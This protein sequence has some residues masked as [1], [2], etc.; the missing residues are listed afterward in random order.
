MCVSS[1]EAK[2]AGAVAMFGEK[3]DDVVRVVDVP[4]VSM[5][6]CGGTHVNNTSEIGVFK[7]CTHTHTRA[8]VRAH[9]HTHTP[10]LLSASF[11]LFC[12]C[13]CSFSEPDEA[14][15]FCPL[16]VLCSAPFYTHTHTHIHTHCATIAHWLYTSAVQYSTA[17]VWVHACKEW[18]R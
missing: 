11:P 17:R 1:Q 9:T 16:S 7:V 8:R 14:R 4:G 2:A 6:L 12:F 5:E 15:V 18:C 13:C 3:Y 10:I